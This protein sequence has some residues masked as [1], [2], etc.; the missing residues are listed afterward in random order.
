MQR[1][2]AKTCHCIVNSMKQENKNETLLEEDKSIILSNDPSME[3]P[4]TGTSIAKSLSSEPTGENNVDRENGKCNRIDKVTDYPTE[5]TESGSIPEDELAAFK[6][7]RLRKTV[8]G[9]IICLVAAALITTAIVFKF[10]FLPEVTDEELGFAPLMPVQERHSL[11]SLRPKWWQEWEKYEGDHVWDPSHPNEPLTAEQ[12]MRNRRKALAIATE[13]AKKHDSEY[14]PATQCQIDSLMS[15]HGMEPD[16]AARRADLSKAYELAKQT[17]GHSHCETL[18]IMMLL[19]RCFP[20]SLHDKTLLCRRGLGLSEQ[21][22]GKDS[23]L[24]DWFAW[25]DDTKEDFRL[26]EKYKNH[27]FYWKLEPGKSES[28]A[29]KCLAKGD[30]SGADEV[31]RK[32]LKTIA[33]KEGLKSQ[34]LRLVADCYCCS[35]EAQGRMKEA[36]KIRTTLNIPR[37]CET[38]HL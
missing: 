17:F 7:L 38:T 18:G 13:V 23:E 35:L 11:R 2:H 32:L 21:V 24:C 12:K 22:F 36:Q 15:L 37:Q 3:K 20:Q 8:G 31:Y 28:I 29:S 5:E 26:R 6:R 14:I 33:A 10:G 25:S 16:Y 4:V 9:V 27:V 19:A 30:F 1:Q 34:R